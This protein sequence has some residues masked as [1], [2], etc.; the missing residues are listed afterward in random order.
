M[1]RSPNLVWHRSAKPAEGF[2]LT[3]SNPVLSALRNKK[4]KISK[5]YI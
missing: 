2:L 5:D 4:L 1:L 3:G